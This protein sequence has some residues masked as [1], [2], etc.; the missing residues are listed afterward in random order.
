METTFRND[1]RQAKTVAV[2]DVAGGNTSGANIDF[3]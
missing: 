3:G 2:L 1:E